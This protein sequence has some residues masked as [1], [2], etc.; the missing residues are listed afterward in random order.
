MSGK[1]KLSRK[2]DRRVRR[3]RDALG[4]ALVALMQEM[5]FESIT[6]QQIL[7]RAEIGRSTFYSHYLDK[8]D[9][10][11]SDMEDFFDSMST[12]LL[13]LARI[14]TGSSRSARCLR[15]S[16]KCALCTPH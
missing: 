3:T 9:L 2:P 8:N 12:L 16:P 15:T 11:L 1:T 6:V 4:D 13:R 7:D 14:R 5:P 10:F